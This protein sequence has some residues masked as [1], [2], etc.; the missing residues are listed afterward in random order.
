M[1]LLTTAILAGAAALAIGSASLPAGARAPQPRYV[2]MVLPDGRLVQLQLASDVEQQ[3]AS[4]A[5]APLFSARRDPG[6]A[7]LERVS[8]M[9][10]RQAALMQMQAGAML[11]EAARF[12]ALPGFLPGMG[13]VPAGL[14]AGGQFYSVSTSFSSAGG[15]SRSMA[16][17]YSGNGL[18]PRVVSSS[19]G[20]C[21]QDG[22]QPPA[23]YQ[24]APH[25]APM[26][27]LDPSQQAT[28]LTP[29]SVEAGYKGMI[30]P[31]VLL[32]HE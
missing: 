22:R 8:A 28:R 7:A 12:S 15:C 18:K 10:D 9:M 17:S 24:T 25:A 11:R 32:S 13:M 23:Q 4:T 21:G 26:F 31:A 1:R 6:F 14:P 5:P 2:A 3:A 16:I 29:A 19:S 30:K 20:D 27:Q